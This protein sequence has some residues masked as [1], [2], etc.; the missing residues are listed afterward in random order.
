MGNKGGII[1]LGVMVAC[2]LFLPMILRKREP[3]QY[4]LVPVRRGQLVPYRTSQ[5]PA[6]TYENEETWDVEYT[7]DGLVQHVVVKRHATQV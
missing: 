1:F 2:A 5:M 3:A 7:P 4:Q 6:A